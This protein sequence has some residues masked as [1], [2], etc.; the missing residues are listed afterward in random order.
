MGANR[1][2]TPRTDVRPTGTKASS[3]QRPSRPAANASIIQEYPE[4][5]TSTSPRK[6][7]LAIAPDQSD[8]PRRG[9]ARTRLFSYNLAAYDSTY[10][11]FAEPPD[12][13][14]WPWALLLGIAIAGVPSMKAAR[15]V[16]AD[17]PTP[18]P[19]SVRAGDPII[20]ADGG[21]AIE[22]VTIDGALLARVKGR[23]V[24]LGAVGLYDQD[25][26]TVSG[27]LRRQTKP[28]EDGP[29]GWLYSSPLRWFSASVQVE[30]P[31]DLDSVILRF[32][33]S[34]PTPAIASTNNQSAPASALEEKRAV[35][36]RLVRG[37]LSRFDGDADVACWTRIA[38]AASVANGSPLK[39]PGPGAVDLSEELVAP[40]KTTM[41]Y[42]GGGVF[43][44][45]SRMG[46]LI[47]RAG[48]RVAASQTLGYSG[49]SDGA[50]PRFEILW[51]GRSIQ[52]AAFFDLSQKLCELNGR[53]PASAAR[54]RVQT[55]D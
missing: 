21:G 44:R 17:A 11:L 31:L 42:H 24:F 15:F 45:Y 32:P 39:S 10:G 34:F 7:D 27:L 38:P 30:K 9:F 47:A 19:A 54:S 6:R 18:I 33:A 48:E 46:Q 26:A 2:P 20:V 51:R 1:R 49:R 35:E 3:R 16:R 14:L 53:A 13:R 8:R 43:T 41:V 22:S 36:A 28:M 40:G 5:F 23:G 52:P 4:A 55:A 37:R 12:R 29:V 25:E 50:K